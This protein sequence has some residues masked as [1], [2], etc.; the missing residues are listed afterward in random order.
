MSFYGEQ[1]KPKGKWD[2]EEYA[3]RGREREQ[4]EYE[5]RQRHG[6]EPTP[7]NAKEATHRA[8]R[9]D[10]YEG[11]NQVTLVPAGAATGKRGKGAGFY[12]EACDLTFK[13]SIQYLDH[14]NSKQHLYATGQVECTRRATLEEV[15][16]RLDY[17]RALKKQQSQN[18]EYDITKQ[19]ELRK[20]LE[21]QEL[22]QKR[23]KRAERKAKSKSSVAPA[24]VTDMSQLM[25]FS[26][27]G[28]SKR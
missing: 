26:G 15:R 16:N 6:R 21:Q 22:E 18:L 25:G 27:F 2:R 9:V 17:L 5:R 1:D 8:Q 3:R 7:E 14:I 28:S 11:L 12:C 24:P 13:D 10:I 20:Q 23:K 19:I 4:A